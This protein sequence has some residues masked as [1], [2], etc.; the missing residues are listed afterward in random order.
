MLAASV[1]QP[2][3]FLA[4]TDW[5]DYLTPAEQRRLETI[6][7]AIANWKAKRETLRNRA[8]LRRHRAQD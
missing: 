3:D 1:L 8:K 5:P 4:M 2:M 6:E 7:A